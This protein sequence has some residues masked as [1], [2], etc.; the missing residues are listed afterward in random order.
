[1]TASTEET[2][3]IHARIPKSLYIRLWQ[4]AKDSNG[5]TYGMLNKHIV[6][7]IQEYLDKRETFKKNT[8]LP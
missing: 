4:Q 7:A 5:S 1:M 6:Q 8:S 2:V 3:Q